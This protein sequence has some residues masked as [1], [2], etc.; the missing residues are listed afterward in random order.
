MSEKNTAPRTKHRAWC[1]IKMKHRATYGHLARCLVRGA[2]FFSDTRVFSAV[3]YSDKKAF[4]AVLYS[5]T[6]A[7]G[8]VLYSDTR[9]FGAVFYCDV[10]YTQLILKADLV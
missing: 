10:P 4:G 8:A 9:V 6:K 3:L 7:F 2:V 1:P 5:D